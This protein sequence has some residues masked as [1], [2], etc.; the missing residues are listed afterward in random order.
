METCVLIPQEFSL[1][2]RNCN[3]NNNNNN[4]NNNNN[5]T[6]TKV[7]RTATNATAVEPEVSVWSNTKMEQ[8][9]ICYPFQ[10]TIRIDKLQVY[11]YLNDNDVSAFYNCYIFKSHTRKNCE[12]V[13][14]YFQV[15]II[16]KK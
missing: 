13:F 12:K 6:A 3:N 1:Y 11:S 10:G 4:T 7:S 2:V 16:L 5:G 8:G 15:E 14:D 9:T